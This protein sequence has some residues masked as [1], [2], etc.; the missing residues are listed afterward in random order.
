MVNHG[1]PHGASHSASDIEPSADMGGFSISFMVPFERTAVYDELLVPDDPLGSS[2]HVDFEILRA[3]YTQEMSAGCVRKATF[4]APFYG[5]T[6]SE[7][8]MAERGP[9][10]GYGKSYIVWRQL[11]SQTR[12]N[13]TG[14]AH[15]YPEFG[16]I[17]EGG[18]D[19]TLV[20]MRYNFK[21][22]DLR[23]PLCCIASCMPSLLRWHLHASVGSVWHL[24]MVRRGYMPLKRPNFSHIIRD[25]SVEEQIRLRATLPKDD[26][27]GCAIM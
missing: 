15:N 24:E 21:R 23:G 13:L 11:E 5:E 17:L 19:G 6:T 8:T 22:I 12:L 26:K 25:L 2:P 18:E 7:L 16:V 9:H 10:Q 1:L 14:D 27:G 20:T 4:V 3:G